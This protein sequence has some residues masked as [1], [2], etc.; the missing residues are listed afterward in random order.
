MLI[1]SIEHN[2]SSFRQVGA[3][4]E[5]ISRMTDIMQFLRKRREACAE[6]K[7]KGAKV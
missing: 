1:I 2:Q 4:R 7:A 3:W 6:M 5:K